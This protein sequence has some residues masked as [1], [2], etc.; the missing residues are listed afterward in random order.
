MTPDEVKMVVQLLRDAGL[1]I[2]RTSSLA[3]GSLTIR[4][5][6]PPLKS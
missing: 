5:Q 3:D 6:R 4:V 2:V 1:V